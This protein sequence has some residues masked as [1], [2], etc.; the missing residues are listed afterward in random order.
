MEKLIK[1]IPLPMAGLMLAVASL[2]NLV[3]SYGS[4]YRNILG[5]ISGLLLLALLLKLIIDGKAVIED[6]KNPVIASVAPTFSMGIMILSTYIKA[7]NSSLALG[8]WAVGLVLH[9]LLIL[10]F[11]KSFMLKLDVKKVLPSYFIVYVGIVVGSVTAPAHNMQSLGQLIFWFGFITYLFLLPMVLYR[12]LVIKAIPE[13]ALP[14]ITII[15]APASLCL[16]GYLSSFPVKNSLLVNFMF[17]LAII[18]TLTALLYLPKLLRLKFYPSY[19]AFTFPFVISGIATKLTNGYLINSGNGIDGLK[20]L[21]KFQ[22][23]F[24]VV[25][26][27]YVLIRYIAFLTVAAGIQKPTTPTIK[28]TA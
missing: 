4:Q 22:E 24:A 8:V 10:F 9:G 11:T 20:Y 19:S 6:L 13:P 3:L 16:A 12:V 1:K 5:I 17:V 25:I 18:M 15:A 28:R 14:L 21:V 7:F 27:L 2:G 23:F 26:V